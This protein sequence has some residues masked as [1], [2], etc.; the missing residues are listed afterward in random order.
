M[1]P[2]RLYA[3]TS[4]KNFPSPIRL[5][6]P[7]AISNRVYLF[8]LHAIINLCPPSVNVSTETPS[9]NARTSLCTQ[10][11]PY[12]FFPHRPFH[13]APSN[14]PT[15]IHFGDMDINRAMDKNG[16]SRC[17][18]AKNGCTLKTIAAESVVGRI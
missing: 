14:V 1:L 6:L 4:E 12:F 11:I 5:P 16:S 8:F 13:Y 7:L 15:T 18:L 10:S 3:S 17:F 2:S 9:S